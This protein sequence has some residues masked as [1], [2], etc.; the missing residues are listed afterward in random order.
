MLK[1]SKI[2][3]LKDYFSDEIITTCISNQKI[4]TLMGDFLVEESKRNL[5]ELRDIEFSLEAKL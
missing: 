4:Y 5:P 1:K 3:R 2:E